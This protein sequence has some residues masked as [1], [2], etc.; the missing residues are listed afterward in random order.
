M[1]SVWD[2]VP[3]DMQLLM[4]KSVDPCTD[5]YTCAA[6]KLCVHRSGGLAHTMANGGAR[7]FSCGAWESQMRAKLDAHESQA[8]L[9]WDAVNERLM[10]DVS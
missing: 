6:W 4:N 1:A 5:F 2:G 9:A 8:E 10:S 3:D 7:S